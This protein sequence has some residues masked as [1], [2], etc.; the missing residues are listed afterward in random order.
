MIM[1]MMMMMIIIIIIIIML[2]PS[3]RLGPWAAKSAFGLRDHVSQI[4]V[5][6][7]GQVRAFGR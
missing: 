2:G 5:R 4:I 6:A 3:A 1:I 7:F